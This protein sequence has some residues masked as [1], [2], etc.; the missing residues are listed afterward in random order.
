MPTIARV[1]CRAFGRVRRLRLMDA[2]FLIVTTTPERLSVE[3]RLP[4]V[5]APEPRRVALVH[6][7]SDD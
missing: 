4:H 6:Y 2:S 3:Q 7:L 5:Y 1:D